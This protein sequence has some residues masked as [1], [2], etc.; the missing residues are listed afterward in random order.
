M[1]TP[2]KMNGFSG[3]GNSPLKQELTRKQKKAK[4]LE[5]KT[6]NKMLDELNVGASD[7]LVSGTSVDMGMS[8]R[9]ASFNYKR[10]HYDFEKGGEQSIRP[11]PETGEQTM[12]NRKTKKYTTYVK[13][14]NP[15]KILREKSN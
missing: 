13:G 4:K 10:A 9:K 2:F 11:N 15:Q 1:R 7:T 14:K 6:Y 5:Q 3:F 12:Y 8:K